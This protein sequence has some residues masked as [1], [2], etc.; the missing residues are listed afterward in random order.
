MRIEYTGFFNN[1]IKIS[2]CYKSFCLVL[3]EGDTEL[4]ADGVFECFVEFKQGFEFRSPYG[5]LIIL[6]ERYH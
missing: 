2:K 5:Q 4:L 3:L 6:L 1:Y